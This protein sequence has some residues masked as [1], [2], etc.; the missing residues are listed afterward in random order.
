MRTRYA[1]LACALTS[2]LCLA[3]A[4]ALAAG[5]E[6][7]LG[8]GGVTVT[9]DN[10]HHHHHHNQS[11][12]DDEAI[13]IAEDNGVRHVRSVDDHFHTIVVSGT[14]RHHHYISVTI[15]RESGDVLNVDRG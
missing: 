5:F 1:I 11:I 9:P 8:S 10:H 14:D 12:S 2:A 6:L 3:S 4:D 13:S 7:H 15:D